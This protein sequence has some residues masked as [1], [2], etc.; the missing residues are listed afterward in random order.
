MSLDE[1]IRYRLL[2]RL[3]ADPDVS[4]RDLARELGISLGKINYCLKALT[5]KGLVKAA[6][7]RNS[8]QKRAYLYKLTPKGISEKADLTVRFLRIKEQERR[9]LLREIEV[10]REEVRRAGLMDGAEELS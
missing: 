6:N 4:Q 3:E 8:R 2:K 5:A 7:F 9:N 10:L 1:E